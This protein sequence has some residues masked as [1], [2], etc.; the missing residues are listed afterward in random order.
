MIRYDVVK[1]VNLKTFKASLFRTTITPKRG[2][3]SE[4]NPNSLLE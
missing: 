3:A 4:I 2:K 1:V